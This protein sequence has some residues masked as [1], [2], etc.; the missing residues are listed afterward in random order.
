M[1]LRK[2]AYSTIIALQIS[3]DR[4]SYEYI[5]TGSPHAH[6]EY[7]RLVNDLTQLKFTILAHEQINGYDN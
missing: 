1:S 4:A 7:T 5:C 2:A 6:A 3:I